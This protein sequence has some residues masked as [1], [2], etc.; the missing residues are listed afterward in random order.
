MT[1]ISRMY[2]ADK[3][4]LPD[5]L[6]DL[7]SF[8]ARRLSLPALS[9]DELFPPPTAS[10]HPLSSRLERVHAAVST[11][12]A[13]FPPNSAM[14]DAYAI[15]QPIADPAAVNDMLDDALCAFYAKRGTVKERP[16]PLAFAAEDRRATISERAAGMMA[17][18]SESPDYVQQLRGHL[19]L[20]TTLT[21]AAL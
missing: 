12:L 20:R 16:T 17:R 2:T 8:G 18:D 7:P 1:I 14:P 10:P 4:L 3:V 6:L 9:S 5:C 15:S 19:F 21:R 11:N 13:S